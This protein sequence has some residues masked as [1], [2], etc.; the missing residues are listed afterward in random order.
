MR[1][2]L[3]VTGI[4]LGGLDQHVELMRDVL[5]E[6]VGILGVLDNCSRTSSII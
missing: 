4:L 5:L 3:I 2:G 6:R 1:K